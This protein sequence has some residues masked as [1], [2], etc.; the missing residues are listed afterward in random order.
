MERHHIKQKPAMLWN[1]KPSFTVSWWEIIIML[2]FNAKPAGKKG[3]L[4]EYHDDMCFV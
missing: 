1:S 3:R 4:T 2:G